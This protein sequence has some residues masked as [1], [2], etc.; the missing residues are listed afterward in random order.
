VSKEELWEWRLHT[1][2]AFDAHLVAG[3]HHGPLRSP[4]LFAR[5]ARPVVEEDVLS[6]FLSRWRERPGAT[7]GAWNLFDLCWLARIRHGS[8][9]AFPAA[10]SAL[11]SQQRDGVLL[12]PSPHPYCNFVVS[13][14]LAHTLLCGDDVD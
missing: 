7:R 4:A 5:L 2:A 13:L 11:I 10:L 8:M 3:D 12:S 14:A 1:Q 6:S 9:P